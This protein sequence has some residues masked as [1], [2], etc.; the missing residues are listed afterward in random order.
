MNKPISVLM[1]SVRADHGG[2]PRHIEL[3]LKHLPADI[4]PFVAC[5]DEP[6]FRERFERLTGGRVFTLPH[7]RF[8]LGYARRLAR[9]AGKQ[10]VDLIHAH[11]KGAGVYA[12]IVAALIRKPCVHTPHGVHV[13]QY[14]P[15]KRCLYRAYENVTARW[16]DH[17]IF[18][19]DEEHAAS[20]AA[21]LWPRT[22]H[23]V[24][25]NGVESVTDA[26]RARWRQDYR[27]RLELDDSQP[28]IMTLSRFDYQKNMSEAFEV[29]R[30]LPDAQFA[31]IG[32][33]EESALLADRARE[34]G[35][36]NIRFLGRIDAPLPW[37]AAADGYLSTS[38]W[39]G[40]PL[41]VLEAMSL[42]VAVVAS[43]VTGHR[44][45]EGEGAAMLYPLGDSEAAA[46]RLRALLDDPRLRRETGERG[47]RLQRERYSAE[48]MAAATAG[49][50]RQVL[51]VAAR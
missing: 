7:R 27:R 39:E 14:S 46:E 37:L 19:S 40:L 28:L 41:A 45:I 38:R 29:A 33:G 9:W 13:V 5:P 48:G 2:G 34:E 51:E 30:R 12:R 35:V 47:R 32:D 49:V 3:L 15:M 31:W 6:P 21:G 4:Q 26:Q 42:G 24:I 17:L 16:V 11:G 43:D 36:S 10:G 1:V 8:D 50:Y 44:A 22:P 20:Q 18:V 23:S 25:V